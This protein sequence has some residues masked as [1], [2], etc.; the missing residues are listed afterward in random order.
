MD[1]ISRYHQGRPHIH[2]RPVMH[3]MD[4]GPYRGVTPL[5]T[6]RYTLCAALHNART[7]ARSVHSTW[8]AHI[9]LYGRMYALVLLLCMCL[10]VLLVQ[11]TC[12]VTRI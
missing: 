8:Y 1:P 9:P 7:H 12:V 4:I 3:K 5:C 2:P 6:T 10:R 11:I